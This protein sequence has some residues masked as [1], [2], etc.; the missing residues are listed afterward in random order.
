MQELG[1]IGARTCLLTIAATGQTSAG[2]R[3]GARVM[4]ERAGT[5]TMIGNPAV[6][7]GSAKRLSASIQ[8][9]QGRGN[10][11]AAAMMQE[12]GT[13]GA[14]VYLEALGATGTTSALARNAMV[15]PVHVNQIADAESVVVVAVVIVVV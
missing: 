9:T 8:C 7:P 3:G 13:I 15:A 1:T 4:V 14:A 12:L 10:A 5:D 6:M 11:A 2:V